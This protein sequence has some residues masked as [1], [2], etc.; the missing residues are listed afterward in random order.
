M[1]SRLP[2]RA[3]PYA[4]T[5]PGAQVLLS[6]A[7]W[8]TQR[9]AA[10]ATRIVVVRKDDVRLVVHEYGS[11]CGILELGEV[12]PRIRDFR[13]WSQPLP[14]VMAKLE[15]HGWKVASD[16]GRKEANHAY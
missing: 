3:L 12:K 9:G 16:E 14:V 4:S 13:I 10:L 5:R 1:S 2:F 15:K 6:W 7:N 8:Q 11:Q